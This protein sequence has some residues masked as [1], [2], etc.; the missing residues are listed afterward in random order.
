M[1]EQPPIPSDNQSEQPPREH[2]FG[3]DV[4]PQ[5]HDL[6]GMKQ[7]RVEEF[8]AKK[9]ENLGT[10]KGEFNDAVKALFGRLLFK[11]PATEGIDLTVA[12][13]ALDRLQSALIVTTEDPKTVMDEIAGD[14]GG[15][16]GP[17]FMETY[18]MV[19]EAFPYYEVL[20]QLANNN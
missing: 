16:T 11:V 15:H 7:F 8:E 18:N 13:S 12:Q 4:T 6:L 14:L 5:L 3:P 2:F 9:G 19:S 10:Y 20:D 17:L 1:S